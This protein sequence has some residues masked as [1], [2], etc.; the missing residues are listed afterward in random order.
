MLIRLLMGLILGL[1]LYSCNQKKADALSGQVVSVVNDEK[2]SRAVVTVMKG[3]KVI[4]KTV[5]DENGYFEVPCLP[6]GTYD[7]IAEKRGFGLMKID[8]MN[9]RKG[10]VVTT[11]FMLIPVS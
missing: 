9:L 1:S 4:A 10:N 6:T 7:V 2:L 5:T 11:H 8:S 3:D